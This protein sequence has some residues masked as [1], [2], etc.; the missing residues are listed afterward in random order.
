V[1]DK[2]LEGKD[3]FSTAGRHFPTRGAQGAQDP[4]MCICRT[5]RLEIFKMFILLSAALHRCPDSTMLLVHGQV[6]SSPESE[7]KVLCIGLL[8]STTIGSGCRCIRVMWVRHGSDRLESGTNDKIRL[9]RSSS[10]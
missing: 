1:V 2:C 8:C 6:D 7:T 4:W 10:T 9:L 5:E 3:K